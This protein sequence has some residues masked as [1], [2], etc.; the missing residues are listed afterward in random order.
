MFQHVDL[1]GVSNGGQL[2]GD[3]QQGLALHQLGD[4][5]FHLF[6]VFWVSVSRSFVQ[7]DDGCVLPDRTC[8]SDP[9]ALTAGELL[10]RLTSHGMDPLRQLCKELRALCLFCRFQHFCICGVWPSDAD[11]LQ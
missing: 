9:L 11:I 10:S 3:D 5:S 7:H 6:L 4:G 2:V 1:I 8:Q